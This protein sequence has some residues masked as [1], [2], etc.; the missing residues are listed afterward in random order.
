MHQVFG[1]GMVRKDACVNQGDLLWK[2]PEFMDQ[3]PKRP[4]NRSQS[5]RNSDEVS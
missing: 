4:G 5:A 2:E 1:D 3:V